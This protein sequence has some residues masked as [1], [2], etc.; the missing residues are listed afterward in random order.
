MIA[1]GDYIEMLMPSHFGQST[2]LLE[3][4]AHELGVESR[5]KARQ[6]RSLGVCAE[7]QRAALLQ[8]RLCSQ[9]HPRRFAH[10]PCARKPAGCL[11]GLRAYHDRPDAAHR[12]SLPLRQRL[13]VPQ[14]RRQDA[15]GRGC[16]PRLGGDAAS[17]LRLG[18][19]GSN[20]QCA[21]GRTARA[22]LGGARLRRRSTYQRRV[23]RIG[24]E[25][26]IGSRFMSLRPMPHPSTRNWVSK[27]GPRRCA[28][29]APWSRNWPPI[30]SNNS[31]NSRA[32][33]RAPSAACSGSVP[34]RLLPLSPP[35]RCLG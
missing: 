29:K 26:V 12:D 24:R 31:S 7:S 14:G 11:P 10:R 16:H 28:K 8:D 23:Q 30:I 2:E 19:T 34:P 17:G 35:W 22:H 5:A 33:L 4:F 21:G 13:L 32:S 1:A 6:T 27:I 9:E 18:G 3:Q 15:F 25:P 20:Q